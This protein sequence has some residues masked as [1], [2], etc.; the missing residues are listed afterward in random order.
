MEGDE[1]SIISTLQMRKIKR[2]ETCTRLLGWIIGGGAGKRGVRLK[3]EIQ[4]GTVRGYAGY[5]MEKAGTWRSDFPF[6]ILSPVL[7]RCPCVSCFNHLVRW[8]ERRQG[9][10]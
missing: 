8:P 1:L 2:A 7:L 9:Q 3:Q 5:E 6:S 4:V 10:F